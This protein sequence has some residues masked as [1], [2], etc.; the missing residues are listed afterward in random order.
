MDIAETGALVKLLPYM[1]Q[2]A[3][4]KNFSFAYQ[5]PSPTNPFYPSDPLN[6]PPTT[7]SDTLPA[8]PP[9]GLWGCEGTIKNLLCPSALDPAA[10]VTALLTV[11]YAVGNGV[12]YTRTTGAAHVFSSAPGRLIMGR[13]NY[14]GV[15]GYYSPS[16][17][18]QYK[19]LLYYKSKE[20]LAR[21]TDGTSNTMLY[22]EYAGGFINWNGS[23]GIPNGIS[24]GSWSAG[25]NYTGFGIYCGPGD[26]ADP[27]QSCWAGF[28]SFHTGN[29]INFCFADG[30]VVG[31]NKNID[32]NTG[33]YL[34]GFQ[35]GVPVTLN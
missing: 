9:S 30:H 26:I 11:D 8:R 32:F 23:G 19:G 4:Y 20:A 33:V 12:D 3:R 7:G 28:S 5:L 15:G 21:C 18:P 10:Y 35:D 27:N 29:I 1:E 25:F 16:Q 14:I 6:R 2:D 31:I 22:G 24:G 13:S 34:S 17:Y